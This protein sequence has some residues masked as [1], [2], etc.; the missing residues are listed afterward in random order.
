MEY[1]VKIEAFEGPLDLLL[2]LINTLEIDIYD[3]PMSEMTEQYLQYVHTMQD[4]QLDIVSEYLVM[5]ATLLAI[6]SKML[7]PKHEEE[8]FDEDV[9]F[10]GEDP[11]DELVERLIEYRKYKDAARDLKQKEEERG[12]MYTKPPID[13]SL[14]AD[15]PVQEVL[16][17]NVSIYDMLGAFNKLLRRKKLQKPITSRITRQEIPIEKRMDEVLEKIRNNQQRTRFFDLFEYESKEYIVVT[18]LAILELMKRNEILVEQLDNF[19]EIY[20]QASKGG[21]LNESH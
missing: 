6:K 2:H 12:K 14:Y 10:F 3:I 16:E 15:D 5:A 20:V 11:R 21:N 7:L 19:D 4:L 1:N 9:D 13:L 18:F 8:I 17:Q